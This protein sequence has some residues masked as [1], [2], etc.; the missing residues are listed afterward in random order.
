MDPADTSSSPKPAAR[1]WGWLAFLAGL[2]TAIWLVRQMPQAPIYSAE[3]GRATYW[4][5]YE[6]SYFASLRAYEGPIRRALAEGYVPIVVFGDSTLRGTGAVGPDIWTRVLERRL[7]ERNRRVRVLN[8]AQNAGDLMGPFLYHHLQ[9]KFPEARYIMQWHFSSEVGIRHQFHYWLT[10]EIILRDGRQNPAVRYSLAVTPVT[11][12]AERA[13]FVLAA[14][15][16]ATNYLEAGNWIRY[17]WLGRPYMAANRQI[18]IQPL[19][20]AQESDLPGTRFVAPDEKTQGYMSGYFLSHQDKRHKYIATL[21]AP[22]RAYLDAMYPPAHRSH[23]LL[24]TLDFNPYYAP[25][26]DPEQMQIWRTMWAKLRQDMATFTD[27]NWLALTGSDG[28]LATDDYVDL[29]HLSVPGQQRL[30]DAVADRLLAPGGW[31]DPAAPNAV[32]PAPELGNR[33][34]E[35]S[36]LTP[37]ERQPMRIFNPMPIRFFSQFGLGINGSFLNA[38]PETRLVFPAAPGRRQLK[39]E[40]KF[41]PGAYENLPAEQATDGVQVEVALLLPGGVREVVFTRLIAPATVETDRGL[42]SLG[43]DFA[44]PAG[45]EIEISVHPGPSGG[46]NRDWFWLGNLSIK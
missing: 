28:G 45:A 42:L 31:F 21:L 30:A 29:G 34:V 40:A 24:L 10:S 5:S 37:D 25:A 15:N 9:S 14:A 13:S 43:A 46:L 3:L 17:R 44:L 38:H 22:R 16:I 41:D 7:Q 23:L 18:K 39:L 19:A 32:T 4:Q 11:T 20:L 36:Q 2:L 26:K 8:Y 1:R 35:M 12:A 33:W 6:T 27:L